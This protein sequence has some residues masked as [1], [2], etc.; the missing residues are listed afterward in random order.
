MK[1]N[2]VKIQKL[3]R[4]RIKKVKKGYTPIKAVFGNGEDYYLYKLS[5]AERFAGGALGFFAGSFVCMVFFRNLF[6]SVVVGAMLIIPGIWKYRDYLKKKRMKNLLLQFRDMME[7]LTAS[8]SAG[9]NTAG[10][11]Q[12]AY[13]DLTNIYGPKADIVQELKLIV[14]GMYNGQRIEEMLENFAMR[15]H[16]DDIESFATI[17][18]VSNRYGGNLKKVVGDTRQIIC[19][20]IETELEIQTLLTA[21]KNELNIMILMP[22]VLM[23]MLSSMGSMSIVQNTPQN[24][25]VKCGAIC[26]F[27]FAYYLGRKIVDIK[28]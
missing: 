25:V 3:K 9:K 20:K 21:N 17:F 22:V 19:D 8:F 15:S 2:R 11:F 1:K 5:R 4:K 24:V 12:D 23:L 7:S 18:E 10:A 6:V 16:L 28:V 14:T 26:L 13:A 27:G